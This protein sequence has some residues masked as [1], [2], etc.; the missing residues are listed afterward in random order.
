[1]R[2]SWI[3]SH[4]D[5]KTKERKRVPRTTAS[6]IEP[7]RDPKPTLPPQLPS[8]AASSL[9]PGHKWRVHPRHKSEPAD[10][11]GLPWTNVRMYERERP[12]IF[13]VRL[14]DSGLA[15]ERGEGRVCADGAHRLWVLWKDIR[16]KRVTCFATK[17]AM[18]SKEW[19]AGGRAL[20]AGIK[21]N[22]CASLCILI[23]R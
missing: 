4:S 11:H 5:I 14:V 15:Q 21:G 10:I 18:R 2:Q 23:Y 8:P 6:R 17:H 3:A 22:S 19:M 16:V 7:Q 13:N 1:M 20:D 12:L 9:D